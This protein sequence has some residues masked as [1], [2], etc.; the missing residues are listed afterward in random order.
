[1]PRRKQTEKQFQSA[2]VAFARVNR[3]LCYHTYDARRS[4]P[5]YPDLT[6]VCKEKRRGVVF[7]ELK[8]SD[9]AQPTPAQRAWGDLL[10]AVG[11]T[12]RYFLWRP[13]D[14]EEIEAVLGYKR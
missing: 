12:V 13:T 5:G 6:L 7:A 8:A 9:T 1:M 4:A 14:W 2:V 11:G 3:W 10:G